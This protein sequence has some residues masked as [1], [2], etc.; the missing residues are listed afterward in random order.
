MQQ[1]PPQAGIHALCSRCQASAGPKR[2]A[3]APATPVAGRQLLRQLQNSNGRM[4]ACAVTHRHP[5][6][7]PPIPPL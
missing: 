1:S 5:P 7:P 2:L 3:L 6:T 4:A